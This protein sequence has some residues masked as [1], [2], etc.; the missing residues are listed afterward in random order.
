MPAVTYLKEHSNADSKIMGSAV[1]GFGLGYERVLDDVR[2][3]FNTGKRADF[4]VV[5]DVYEE[6]INHYRA[7]G[8]GAA[9]QAHINKMLTQDYKLVYDENFYQIYARRDLQLDK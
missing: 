3:G 9:L 2:F 6:G 7:G 5:N 4:L 1:L 8:E